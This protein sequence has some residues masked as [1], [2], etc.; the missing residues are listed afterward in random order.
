MPGPESQA[1]GLAMRVRREALRIAAQ[2][3]QLDQFHAVFEDA[4]ARRDLTSARVAFARFAD[5]LEAH[6]SLE[7]E[8]Y[9]PA[10]HGHRRD[11]TGELAQLTREHA[12]LR[13]GVAQLTS[14]LAGSDFAACEL[15]L[16]A[17]TA[18]LLSHER[19]EE[20]LLEGSPPAGVA[21]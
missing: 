13:G 8:F 12:A 9:F 17:W 2:H 4:L 21:S 7:E 5:A 15:E 3:H 10:L 20:A 19:H 1:A 6:F 11:L 16:A 18:Q 14:E